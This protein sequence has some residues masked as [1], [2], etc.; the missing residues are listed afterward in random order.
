MLAVGLGSP[1]TVTT[2]VDAKTLMLTLAGRRARRVG[3]GRRAA[4]LA[5]AG[6]CGGGGAGAR[7]ARGGDR[8][9]MRCSTT[10]RISRR[11]RAMKS[12]RRLTRASP[13]GARRCSPTS[14]NTRCTSCATWTSAARLRLPPP[15]LGCG[16]RR[17][18]GH[19]VELDRVAPA[20]LR[21]YPLIVTRRDPRRASAGRV[22]A[23][24]A[25]H[26]LP[27]VGTTSRGAARR[28]PIS[29]CRACERC[30][31]RASRAW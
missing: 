4:R 24:L 21:A 7:A 18:Y 11:P 29:A 9:R 28:S 8:A 27:G 13:A 5:A 3:G 19:P 25:G 22:P 12:S 26:L 14:T 15:A 6:C 2:W 20:A 23:G 30:D 31:A 10:P 16:S 1:R 17:V